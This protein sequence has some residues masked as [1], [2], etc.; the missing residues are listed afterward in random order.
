MPGDCTQ[1]TML[2]HDLWRHSLLS[3]AW[4]G[5]GSVKCEPLNLC[6]IKVNGFRPN[7]KRI[8]LFN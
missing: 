8:M 1:G 2:E 4:V 5:Y 7:I 6:G 3:G